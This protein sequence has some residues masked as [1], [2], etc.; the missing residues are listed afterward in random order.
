MGPTSRRRVRRAA[1]GAAHQDATATLRDL[2]TGPSPCLTLLSPL[3]TPI[4][5]AARSRRAIPCKRPK[6]A[7]K[8]VRAEL[9]PQRGC[10][11]TGPRLW[12]PFGTPIT[13]VG[14]S[15]AP[16]LYWTGAPFTTH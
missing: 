10:S 6:S 12:T 11:F 13:R 4:R 7:R 9:S 3:P 2:L 1:I 8:K 14:Y 5:G 16:A 15:C